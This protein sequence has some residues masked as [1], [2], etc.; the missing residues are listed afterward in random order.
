MPQTTHLVAPRPPGIPAVL[1][2]TLCRA[3]VARGTGGTWFGSGPAADMQR[4][5]ARAAGQRGGRRDQ[6]AA[7]GLPVPELGRGRRAQPGGA[8]P[9]VPSF[10]YLRR[11]PGDARR[12]WSL[13]C[14]VAPPR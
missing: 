10:P 4:R 8:T 2:R 5:P 11:S 1:L 7:R 14:Y 12:V 13:W 3:A 6:P 9:A